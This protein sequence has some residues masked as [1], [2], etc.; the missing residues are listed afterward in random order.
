MLRFFEKYNISTYYLKE[1]FVKMRLGGATN[2]SVKNIYIQNLECIRAFKLNGLK[3]N[4]ILY[5]LFRIVPKF[6][7]F[8]RKR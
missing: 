7:Q 8:S 5:P 6:F 2:L 4:V 3:V 1:V